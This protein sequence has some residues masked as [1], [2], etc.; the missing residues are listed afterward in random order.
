MRKN[1]IEEYIWH[2]IGG[3]NVLVSAAYNEPGELRILPIQKVAN[4]IQLETKEMVASISS[5][6]YSSNQNMVEEGSEEDWNTDII[7]GFHNGDL[8]I[9]SLDLN[10]TV[11]KFHLGP[12]MVNITN[13]RN[14]HVIAYTPTKQ[15]IVSR[16]V[17]S[18]K[19][20]KNSKSN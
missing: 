17:L 3:K 15:Y 8:E 6:S 13:Y 2:M 16:T 7:V 4:K 18:N 12:E 19:Y 20:I 14:S 10:R 5:I 1:C 11:G 9:Y